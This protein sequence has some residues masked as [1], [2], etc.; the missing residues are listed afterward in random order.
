MIALEKAVS[1]QSFIPRINDLAA[2]FSIEI[3]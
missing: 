3:G 2:S 1:I